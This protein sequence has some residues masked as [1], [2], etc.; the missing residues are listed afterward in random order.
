M[1]NLKKLKK[2][3]D[4]PGVYLFKDGRGKIL[5]IGKATSL[6]S[7]VRSYFAGNILETRGQLIEQMIDLAKKVDH[8]QTDTVL[9]ALILEANLIRRYKPH[10]NTKDKDD[11][12]FNTV[13]ITNEKF[14]QVLIVRGREVETTYSNPD[15]YKAIYGPFPNSGALR[16]AMKIIRRIFPYRDQKCI[17]AEEQS[18]NPRSCFNR[19]IGLCPGVCTGEISA[20]EYAKIIRHLMMFFAGKKKQLLKSLERDMKAYAKNEEFEKAAMIRRTVFALQHIQ[21]VALIRREKNYYPTVARV[22]VEAF[23]I[24]HMAGGDT[25]GVMTVVENGQAQPSEYRLFKIRQDTRGDDL[26]ALGE[27]LERRFNHPEWYMPSL[28]VIDGGQTHLRYAQEVLKKINITIPTVSVVKDE[29]H[30]AKDILND[31]I[32]LSKLVKD[33]K[34]EILLANSESHRFAIKYHKSLRG[35]TFLS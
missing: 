14:P 16:E 20:E 8:I 9:E 1:I 5:Y 33:H 13:V 27:V 2:L 15:F 10:H 26:K 19:Q 34:N 3:P 12:S 32:A 4:A 24:A 28:I 25:V 35:K 18:A 31:D 30:K 21:D 7:R 22:R 6:R 29:T 17:P 23:D 11:K